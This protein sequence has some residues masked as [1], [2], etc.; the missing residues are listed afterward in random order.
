MRTTAIHGKSEGDSTVPDETNASLQSARPLAL[1]DRVRMSAS[2]RRL[3][4]KY[5]RREGLIVG[6]GSPSGRRVRFDGLRSV[7]TI[8]IDYLEKV[9]ELSPDLE[10]RC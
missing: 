8:H 3:H 1:G 10:S 7:Q 4:P 2:G 5:G 6:Q 9:D